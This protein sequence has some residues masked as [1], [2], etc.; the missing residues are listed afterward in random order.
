MKKFLLATTVLVATAGVAAAEV[1]LSG[2]ARMGVI[3]TFKQDYASEG[4][5]VESGVAFTSRARVTFTLSGETDSGIAFGGS[6]RADNA[7]GITIQ[8]S[9]GDGF[10]DPTDPEEVNNGGAALGRSGSVFISGTFGKLT[11]GDVDN[12]ALAAV[13]QVAG[14]GLTGL[15]DL[16]EISYYSN[17]GA[18]NRPVALYEYSSNGFTGYASLTN[19]DNYTRLVCAEEDAD[20]VCLEYDEVDV[21][22][23]NVNSYAVGASYS[24]DNYT[25]GLGY[26]FGDTNRQS[27]ATN[28]NHWVLGGSATFGGFTLEAVVGQANGAV[29]GNQYAVS[30]TYAMDAWAFT[31]FYP[32]ERSLKNDDGDQIGDDTA[33]GIGVSYDLGG[34]ASVVG[35]YAYDTG[36]N[37]NIDGEEYDRGGAWDLGISMS[38]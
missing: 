4:A 14:V 33:Y 25:I 28:T 22:N 16:N 8:D 3:D 30:G 36:T 27:S 9:N 24:M 7:S 35:G 34:G 2:D 20:G 13:G 17:S 23:S 31:A 32:D 5:I 26:E 37:V 38:F 1:T 29:D 18:F 10:I 19:P 15:G 21:A 6:F 11:M 12:A